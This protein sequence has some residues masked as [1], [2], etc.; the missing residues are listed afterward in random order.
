M[1]NFA[2]LWHFFVRPIPAPAG[3]VFVMTAMA[4]AWFDNLRISG[5]LVIIELFCVI[6]SCMNQ[7]KSLL[8]DGNGAPL[9]LYHGT[10]YDFDYFRPLTHFGPRINAETNLGEGKWKRDPNIDITKP[11]IIPIN[12]SEANYPEIPD[13]N[14]HSVQNWTGILFQYMCGDQIKDYLKALEITDETEFEKRHKIEFDKLMGAEIT[15]PSEFDFIC[16]AVSGHISEQDIQSELAAETLFDIHN[17]ENLFM[18]RMILYFESIGIHGFKYK[19]FTEGIGEYSY[20]IF[21]QNDIHRLDKSLPPYKNPT[22]NNIRRIT[23]LKNRFIVSRGPRRLSDNE[24]RT[25]LNE[26]YQ[27]YVFRFNELKRKQISAAKFEKSSGNSADNQQ[28]EPSQ[29]L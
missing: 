11:K 14:D 12:I 15:V 23:D 5:F 19:N 2:G 17:A 7:N 13:L 18:Q 6:H 16:N 4:R 24:K 9:V 8:L 29:D 1:A 10:Y 26:L 21:R 27:F 28:A 22:Q 3:A 25:L 20:I